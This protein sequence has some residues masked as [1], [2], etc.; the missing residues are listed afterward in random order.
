MF[1]LIKFI[2]YYGVLVAVAL[3]LGLIMWAFP[4]HAQLVCGEHPE[5]VKNLGQKYSEKPVS[6]GLGNN[7]SMIEIFAS[8]KGT[9]TIVVTRPDG[10]SCL[11]A[12]GESWESITNSFENKPQT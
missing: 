2:I 11:V 6:M 5:V 9:F 4:A 10:K 8:K 1:E 12:T 7:G 3:I